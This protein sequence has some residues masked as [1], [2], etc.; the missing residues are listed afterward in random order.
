MG[1]GGD[2]WDDYPVG[3]ATIT[4]NSFSSSDRRHVVAWG[5]YKGGLGYE[6]PDWE[7]IL[8]DNTFDK[9][10][11]TR[12]PGGE[13]RSW[14][15][16]YSD[17]SGTHVFKNIVGIYS[18][19]QRYAID[20]AAQAGDTVEVLP[21]TY[22]EQVSINKSLTVVG[23]GQE[24]TIIK[25]PASMSTVSVRGGT[26]AIQGVVS[27]VGGSAH[28]ITVDI[29]GFTVDGNY[30]AP[31][32]SSTWFAGI[33]YSNAD[34]TIQNNTITKVRQ[35]PLALGSASWRGHGAWIGD[36]ST[37]TVDS[38][39]ISE[40]QRNGIEVRDAAATATVT[41]N[42]ITGLESPYTVAN[43]VTFYG[44]TNG[45]ISGNTVSGCRYTGAGSGNDFYSGTQA[46]GINA[47]DA[48][49][50]F[51]IAGNTVTDSDMGIYSRLASGVGNIQNNTVE[52]NLYFGV[53]FRK[54]DVTATGNYVSGREV[55][56]LVPSTR[57]ASSSAPAAN[58]NSIAGNTVYGVRND[59]SYQTDATGNWWGHVT[60]PR[61]NGQSCN[62][63]T[64]SGD[65][66]SCYVLF[67]PWLTHG[68]Q[69]MDGVADSVDNCPTV[70]NPDQ[71]NSDGGRRPNGS[72]IPDEWASN[73]SQDKLG[74]ACDPDDDNDRLPDAQEFDDHC[75]Y[76]L[77]ADSYGDRVVDGFEVA[78][79]YDPCNAASKPTWVG[80]GDSDGDGLLDGWERSGYNTCAFA[81]DTTPGWA[82]CIVP[83]DSD[84]DGCADTLEVLDLNGD[85]GVNV[86]DQ[87]ALALRTSGLP[88]SDPI[89]DAIFDVNK[90]GGVNV[91]DDLL[92][93]LNNCDTKPGQLGCPVCPAE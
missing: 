64:G 52:D 26:Q 61:S 47:Y 23:A 71:L 50:T 19:I 90:D 93:A 7:G 2:S 66:V 45:S 92:M 6:D 31:A 14:E 76:R 30:V 82:T 79:G 70:Y 17:D 49:G 15:T 57:S 78:T 13:M 11:V 63:A 24:T 25:A 4:D 87:F 68:D 58:F 33:V 73:P 21:G 83:R 18:G 28:G 67:N 54:G 3:A 75:P 8:E 80:G 48:A 32:I 1:P 55:G 65:K 74:D 42:T 9:G 72:R 34:G 29:S 5:E 89:S 38:N 86:G 12:K 22:V 35:D 43:G 27:A 10:A 81:G 37:V 16:E 91:E 46:A 60:G 40:S 41:D 36:S 84:G 88:P 77:V 62:I 69:D 53:V 44:A 51:S 85:R 59:A 20:R 39:T 56:I